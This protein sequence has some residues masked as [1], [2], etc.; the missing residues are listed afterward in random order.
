MDRKATFEM[1]VAPTSFMQSS[2]TAQRPMKPVVESQT[3]HCSAFS[4]TIAEANLKCPAC[5]ETND[6]ENCVQVLKCSPK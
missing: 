1:L 2:G 5:E 6:V 3:R 4:T